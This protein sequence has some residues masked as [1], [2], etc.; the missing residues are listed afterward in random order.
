MYL[1]NQSREYLLL[2]QLIYRELLSTGNVE[3]ALLN[4]QST[5]ELIQIY[6]N[7]SLSQEAVKEVQRQYLNVLSTVAN[8]TENATQDSAF[9][10]LSTLQD[11]I[12][13]ATDNSV[14]TAALAV[15]ST[16]TE[17]LVLDD[18]E[19]LEDTITD[20][21]ASVVDL[22]IQTIKDQL[23]NTREKNSE[24]SPSPI[25]VMDTLDSLF[26]LQTVNRLCGETPIA[27]TMKVYECTIYLLI[28]SQSFKML[29]AI[30][31]P[32]QIAST[33]FS[34]PGLNTSVSFG[35]FNSEIDC[36]TLQLIALDIDLGSTNSSENRTSS[37]VIG[38]NLYP[39]TVQLYS[40]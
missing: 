24:S 9:V 3:T 14:P 23:T 10:Q 16:I 38:L 13:M 36:F 2:W 33:G 11:I 15:A 18:G 30:P 6:S 27:T 5:S 19:V 29:T 21:V 37:G 34:P 22:A 17:N 8:S 35:S 26:D 7:S 28:Y 20:S 4:M 32:D 12:T 25:E 1:Q 39:G 40:K 31:T